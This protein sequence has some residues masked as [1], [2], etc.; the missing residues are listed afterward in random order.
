MVWE[1]D[2]PEY[3]FML[4]TYEIKYYLVEGEIISLKM[5]CFCNI[6]IAKV[7]GM[8]SQEYCCLLHGLQTSKHINI[9]S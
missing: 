1:Q 9:T 3:F 4:M 8:E 2:L 7:K 6:E 5:L